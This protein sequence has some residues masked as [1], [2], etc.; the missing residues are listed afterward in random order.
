MNTND[1]Q[2]SRTSISLP[3]KLA[4]AALAASLG[5]IA[6]S[7]DASAYYRTARYVAGA[8]AL[9][10]SPVAYH[11]EGYGYYGVYGAYAGLYPRDRW[12]AY[13]SRVIDGGSR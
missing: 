6:V 13:A 12:M 5:S 4:S 2:N 8:P 7:T 1:R 9:Y 10:S 3:V 11:G